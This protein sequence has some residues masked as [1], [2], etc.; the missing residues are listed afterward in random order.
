VSIWLHPAA[1]EGGGGQSTTT[2]LAVATGMGPGNYYCDPFRGIQ[3]SVSSLT[4]TGATVQV[5][6]GPCTAPTLPTTCAVDNVQQAPETGVDCGGGCP[7]LCQDNVT[8]N[9]GSDCLST[10][11]T[12]GRCQRTTCF[13][14]VL[15]GVETDTDCGGGACAPC[16]VGKLCGLNSDC[17]SGHCGVYPP[18]PSETRCYV[19]N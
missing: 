8:C 17:Q 18:S 15:D 10:V 13:N 6:R 14:G 7:T 11:C 16:A 9:A 4:A 19:P 3:V 12:A 1:V 2:D 5:T